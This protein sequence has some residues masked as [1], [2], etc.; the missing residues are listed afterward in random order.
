M[1]MRKK[2]KIVQN[3]TTTLIIKIKLTIMIIICILAF[4]FV[5]IRHIFPA[6][7]TLLFVNKFGIFGFKNVIKNYKIL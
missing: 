3:G 1:L 5:T 4:L 7:I 6:T 2:K